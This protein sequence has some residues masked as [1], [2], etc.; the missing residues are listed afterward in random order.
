[1]I[2]KKSA[3]EWAAYLIGEMVQDPEYSLVYEDDDLFEVYPDEADQRVIHDEM[4]R[5]RVRVYWE[6]DDE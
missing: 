1:M 4:R 5:A 2:D 3:R 6:E